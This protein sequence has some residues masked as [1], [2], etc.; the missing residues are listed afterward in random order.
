MPHIRNALLAIGVFW[1]SF[2]WFFYFAPDYIVPG[3]SAVATA[4]F[5]AGGILNPP[6]YPWFGIA[7]HIFGFLPIQSIAM[8]ANILACLCGGIS[9]LLLFALLLVLIESVAPKLDPMSSNLVAMFASLL[10]I[11]SPV[12]ISHF[13][14]IEKYSVSILFFQGLLLLF[15]KLSEVPEVK[16]RHIFSFATLSV[17][18]VLAHYF[19]VPTVVFCAAIL[20]LRHRKTVGL[21][22]L[23]SIGL[24]VL[25]G[26]TPI[27]YLP[28]SSF[29]N[30]LL[31]WWDPES[32]EAI[33]QAVTRRQYHGFNVPLTLKYLENRLLFQYDLLWRQ[34]SLQPLM[35]GI[36]LFL[37]IGARGIVVQR[38]SNILLL[39][40]L[41][42]PLTGECITIF[43]RVY[44]PFQSTPALTLGFD[45]YSWSYYLQWIISVVVLLGVLLACIIQEINSKRL[46]T[47][48]IFVLFL[49]FIPISAQDRIQTGRHPAVLPEWTANLRSILQ[50]G[51]TVLV[52]FDALYFSLFVAQNEG[53]FP[54]DI[55][56]IHSSLVMMPWYH[57]TLKRLYPEW[58]PLVESQS[59]QLQ[60]AGQAYYD[61]PNDKELRNIWLEKVSPFVGSILRHSNSVF[62]I[63]NVNLMPMNQRAAR[64]FSEQPFL[65]GTW[66][67]KS[68][69]EM[70]AVP[71]SKLKFTETFKGSVQEFPWLY[72]FRAALRSDW[73]Q[74]NNIQRQMFSENAADQKEFETFLNDQAQD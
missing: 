11:V 45:R 4:A 23:L 28:W 44:D 26:L 40:T 25:V 41:L 32:L 58:Y 67:F 9:A 14:T 73:L 19:F 57:S 22:W 37:W 49:I 30:P 17:W 64:I 34:W 50:P 29:Q 8:K 56:I 42:L 68:S 71:W 54:K 20:T 36:P 10:W 2:F 52:S 12:A 66:G 18:V 51:D 1:L 39:L 35:I 59:R 48:L 31:D 65:M 5:G 74:I 47:S 70:K 72:A 60:R 15:F 62:L 61:N 21:S 27:L 33:W 55:Q 46:R 53:H 16:T 24:G 3:S 13:S 43:A 6:S 38:N 63:S 69:M 7:S